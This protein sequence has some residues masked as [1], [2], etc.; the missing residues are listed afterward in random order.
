MKKSLK[1][2]IKWFAIACAAFIL[3]SGGIYIWL[4]TASPSL[5][6]FNSYI[7]KKID[8]INPGYNIK[9]GDIRPVWSIWQL[10]PHIKITETK[11][12]NEK[13]ETQAELPEIL[14]ILSFLDFING[15]I[16][17]VE[18]KIVSPGIYLFSKKQ[19]V[20]NDNPAK[21]EEPGDKK[22]SQA[23]HTDIISWH[24]KNILEQTA[25]LSR[26]FQK[27]HIINP[28]IINKNNNPAQIQDIIL[29]AEHTGSGIVLELTAGY[30]FN[31]KKYVLNA[32]VK[33]ENKSR[34]TSLNITGINPAALG[35]FFSDNKNIKAFDLPFNISALI[36]INEQGLVIIDNINLEN[37]TGKI[38]DPKIWK[39]SLLI[40]HIQIQGSLTDSLSCFK[41]D[42]LT[43]NSDGPVLKGS[44]IIKYNE[45]YP[46]IELDIFVTSL[47][48]LDAVRYWPYKLE[49][50]VRNW[51]KNSIY[52]GDINNAS[53]KIRLKPEDFYPHAILPADSIKAIVPFKNTD[54]DYYSP[55]GMV[56]QIRGTAY[57]TAHDIKIDVYNALV[58]NSKITKGNIYI[59]GLIEKI[60]KISIK[61]DLSGPC[62]DLR[63]AVDILTDNNV[64]PVYIDKGHA[65]TRLT[66]DFPLTDFDEKKIKYTGLSNIKNMELK[67][68]YGYSIFQ[69]DLFVQIV[70]DD[71]YFKALNGTVSHKKNLEQPV[72]IKTIEAKTAI[73]HNPPG[74]DIN[75]FSSDI[76]GPV[77]QASGH[78]KIYPDTQDIDLNF[79]VDNLKAD[80]AYKYWPVHLA[81]ESR[82]WIKENLLDGRITGAKARIN[83]EPGSFK[84]NRIMKNAVEAFI[85]FENLI[86]NYYPP[87]PVLTS[88]KGSAKIDTDSIKIDIQEGRAG[89]SYLTSSSAVIKGI[90]S[91]IPQIEIKSSF[92]GPAD[93]IIDASEALV[94][95]YKGPRSKT[96]R[97]K[98]RFNISF[99]L[100]DKILP[101]DIKFNGTSEIDKINLPDY[102]GLSLENGNLSAQIDNLELKASG[103]IMSGKTR[104]NIN[105]ESQAAG[106]WKPG[107]I[108]ESEETI[109]LTG[110]LDTDNFSD[111]NIPQF[112]GI[113]GTA[114]A[115]ILIRPS[116]SLT[117]INAIF[118]LAN[119]DLDFKTLGWQKKTGK[120]AELRIKAE[121]SQ[122]EIISFSNL[123][124]YGDNFEASGSGRAET[125]SSPLCQIFLDKLKFG[126]NDLKIKL[127]LDKN[128][129]DAE[130]TGNQLDAGPVINCM[131]DQD[132]QDKDNHE[133]KNQDILKTDPKPDKIT[134]QINADI[135]KVLLLN[136]KELTNVK[137]AVKCIG[138]SLVSAD[139]KGNWDKQK[140]LTLKISPDK[141]ENLF[142]M[143]SENAEHLLKGLN[144]FSDIQKGSLSINAR[145]KGSIPTKNQVSGQLKI[146]DF[147]LVGVHLLVKLISMASFV[148]IAEQ[149]QSQGVAFEKLEAD[150]YYNDNIL[151]IENGMAEGLSMGITSRGQAD[152]KQGTLDLQGVVIPVNILN[153]IVET[154]PVIGKFITGDG[155]IATNYSA[156]GS[157]K[158]PDIDIKPMS[159]LAVGGIRNIIDNL[160]LQNRKNIPI[161]S[162]IDGDENGK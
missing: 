30:M 145:Y 10:F 14:L 71:L 60:S 82:E 135:K 59:S 152:L 63:Q 158:N 85:S 44:G 132:K 103:R 57:F 87:L 25:G 73:L 45:K 114:N 13:S 146:D 130:I 109:R 92:Q 75:S 93:D 49:K 91:N 47:N 106:D 102:Y 50:D 29:K 155:I 149:L 97:A 120:K 116:R 36:K 144:L 123:Y 148:G 161:D 95:P 142:I 112:S 9:I 127:N 101:D 100:K 128:K 26:K 84:N 17:P 3:V 83:I 15:K 66:F 35:Y 105:L 20:Q 24:I 18:I 54:L 76:D 38:S 33:Q 113:K 153:K 5:S 133:Q 89:N 147:T 69:K 16:E 115:D 159:T 34:K 42:K 68:F 56:K 136:K 6:I 46:D 129:Y 64:V 88:A 126:D 156:T 74:M 53:L 104:I 141:Q 32:L 43:L 40:K 48:V 98:T 2:F 4:K 160:K 110:T 65:E 138:K 62:D 52:A 27:L 94:K 72:K 121:S 12:Y 31:N 1:F 77:V 39:K 7:E 28:V 80:Q 23:G 8:E 139:L 122:D 157:Y 140:T 134:G 137:G 11:I 143:E 90:L 55:L 61:A 19:T 96:A 22:K 58:N 119:I 51:I 107:S 125:G 162:E 131:Y 86:L 117:E 111:F 70:Q 78:V 108:M 99:P 81:G 37:N 67:D 154:I 21:I 79:N 151:K 150:F 124:L 41:I 118:D